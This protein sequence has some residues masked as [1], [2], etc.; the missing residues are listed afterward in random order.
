VR[1]EVQARFNDAIQSKLS[2]AVWSSGCKSWYLD[3]HGKN[4]TLWQG[5]TFQF[6]KATARL[7]EDDYEMA[8]P[9]AAP[10]RVPQAA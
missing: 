3:A 6:R 2:D 5:F 1:P 9:A 7:R 4:R 8:P 10:L